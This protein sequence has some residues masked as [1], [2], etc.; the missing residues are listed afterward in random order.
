[1]NLFLR[2]ILGLLG[3]G[4]GPLCGGG[5]M[6]ADISS[7]PGVPLE[8][9]SIKSLGLALSAA[10]PTTRN[11]FPVLLTDTIFTAF[12]PL[13]LAKIGVA[14]GPGPPGGG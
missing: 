7:G 13:T 10:F 12:P 1:M 5:A 6:P 8:M 14:P 3:G 9:C 11:P 4:G 2:P